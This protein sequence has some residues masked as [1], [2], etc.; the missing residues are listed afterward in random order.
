MAHDDS[1]VEYIGRDRT[2]KAEPA[3][4]RPV[5]P[6]AMAAPAPAPAPVIAAE[7]VKHV[8]VSEPSHPGSHP[9]HAVLRPRRNWEAAQAETI[10]ARAELVA[11]TNAL[12]IAEKAEGSALADWLKLNPAPSADAVYR[13]HVA[14]QQAERAARVA[15]GLPPDTRT[16]P[17][18]NKSPI[19]QFAMARGKAAA[20]SGV[21]LRSNVTRR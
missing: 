12:R 7:P 2:V 9:K 13:A 16:A 18:I 1:E 3:R 20:R 14:G 8:T 10:D 17:V 19:D 11:A 5:A 6:R 15:A 21:P 4:A